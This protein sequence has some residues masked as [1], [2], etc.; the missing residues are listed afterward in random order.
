MKK[1]SIIIPVF[2][3]EKYLSDCLNSVLLQTYHNIEIIV[4]DDGSTDDTT[5]IC[6]EYKNKDERVIIIKKRNGGVSS[7]RNIGIKKAVGD[8]ILFIDSD[9]VV[10]DNFVREMLNNIDND[11]MMVVCGLIEKTIKNNKK[12]VY[13]KKINKNKFNFLMY[14]H[15]SIGGFCCNKIYSRKILN[16]KNIRFDEKIKNYEDML[17]NI[18]YIPYIKTVKYI[19]STMYVYNQR[20]DSAAKVDGDKA[21]NEILKAVLSMRDIVPDDSKKVLD[22]IILEE[23]VRIRY[24]INYKIFRKYLFDTDVPFSRRSKMFL[25][26]VFYPAYKAYAFIK[27]RGYYEN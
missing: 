25:K 26:K 21:Y 1:V 10:P 4:V 6:K 22:Y 5:S 14:A 24:P 9:D 19:S 11:T 17:F 13:K 20:M 2:N 16:D 8:Y 15:N 12:L 27:K 18:R 3:G 23:S 7:A